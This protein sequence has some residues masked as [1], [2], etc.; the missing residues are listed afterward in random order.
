MFYFCNGTV[1]KLTIS[2]F[3]FLQPIYLNIRLRNGQGN[4]GMDSTFISVDTPVNPKE[5]LKKVI[6]INGEIVDATDI[7]NMNIHDFTTFEQEQLLTGKLKRRMTYPQTTEKSEL[8]KQL[9]FQEVARD[10]VRI[11]NVIIAFKHYKHRSDSDTEDSDDD[12]GKKEL[13]S[14][15]GVQIH[16]L[17]PSTTN[18]GSSIRTST[19]ISPADDSTKS[20]NNNIER[21]TDGI[22]QSHD[23]NYNPNARTSGP[24]TEHDH[25]VASTSSLPKHD[26]P[27]PSMKN[28]SKDRVD[29]PR[30]R[31]DGSGSKSGCPC[32]IL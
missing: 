31:I 17:S 3:Y 32:V 15:T 12:C 22:G 19:V 20:H 13:Q 1:L 9:S 14:S 30:G 27:K 10:V 5:P 25:L 29:K 11:E 7:E 21:K 28:G 6:S 26:L 4:Q 23:V 24:Q 16:V 8:R 2:A 18:S